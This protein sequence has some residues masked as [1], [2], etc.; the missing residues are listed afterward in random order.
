MPDI[1]QIT[2]YPAGYQISEIRLI[3]SVGYPTNYQISGI[4]NQPDI[5][6]P[7]CFNIWYPVGHWKYP[8]IQPNRISGPTLSKVR[9]GWDII[10]LFITLVPKVWWYLGKVSNFFGLTSLGPIT[11][12]FFIGWFIKLSVQTFQPQIVIYRSVYFVYHH[13][14]CTIINQPLSYPFSPL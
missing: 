14:G 4:K 7:D 5:R 1:W 3:F 2:V 9:K 6:Y 12:W 11:Y 10:W 8:D 13:W